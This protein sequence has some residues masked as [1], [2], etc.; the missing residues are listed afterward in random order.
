MQLVVD[1]SNGP[2]TS[3]A[4]AVLVER[5]RRLLAVEQRAGVAH[6]AATSIAQRLKPTL[7]ATCLPVPSWPLE[8]VGEEVDER[9]IVAGRGDVA[10]QPMVPRGSVEPGEAAGVRGRVLADKGEIIHAAEYLPE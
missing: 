6:H 1:A 10:L 4:R 2:P 7:T 8:A 3:R 9:D 5:S